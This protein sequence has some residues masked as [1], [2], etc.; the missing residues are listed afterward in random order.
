[1]IHTVGAADKPLAIANCH[2][3]LAHDEL[4]RRSAEAGIPFIDG[5][6]E[7]ML[8]VKHVLDQRDYRRGKTAAIRT[9]PA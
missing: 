1:M 7:G 3:D 8:A 6:H 4:C 5:T 9:T 2:G